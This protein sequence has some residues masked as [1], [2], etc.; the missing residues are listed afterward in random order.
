MSHNSVSLPPMPKTKKKKT[1]RVRVIGTSTIDA[2]GIVRTHS[3]S[4][5]KVAQLNE[6]LAEQS[7]FLPNLPYP[8][9]DNEEDWMDVDSGDGDDHFHGEDIINGEEIL[10]VSHAGGEWAALFRSMRPP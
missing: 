6:L 4:R 3:Y 1:K 2:T 9:G 7:T 5:T 8:V 10:P